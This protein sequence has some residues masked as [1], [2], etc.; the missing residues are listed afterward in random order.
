MNFIKLPINHLKEETIGC[1]GHDRFSCSAFTR[2][3]PK[4]IFPCDFD[5][6]EKLIEIEYQ[7]GDRNWVSIKEFFG[8]II[9]EVKDIY[10]LYPDG[11]IEDMEI[12][13]IEI[14]KIKR[15]NYIKLIFERLLPF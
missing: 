5:K 8:K 1:N 4:G 13:G 6:N 12:V 7:D 10:I 15:T 2:K 11:A 9:A 3:L 14:E